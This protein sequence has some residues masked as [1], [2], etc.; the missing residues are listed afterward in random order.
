MSSGPRSG[1]W[2]LGDAEIS[3]HPHVPLL[4][5]R[6]ARLLIVPVLTPGVRAMTLG[7]VVLVRAGHAGDRAL[8]AHELVHVRQWRERGAA[9]FLVGYLREYLRGR[10]AG[11]G[12]RAAYSAIGAEREA[13]RL[14]AGLVPQGRVTPPGY[15]A[16]RR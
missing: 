8:L 11:L 1:W 2:R 14:A 9:G 16:E 10:R 13:R 3:R 7:R 15:A 6:R 4:D 5:R 12:H